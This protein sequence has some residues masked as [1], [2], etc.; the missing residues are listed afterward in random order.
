MRDSISF[1]S[2]WPGQRD[3]DSVSSAVSWS[4]MV[5]DN[6]TETKRG[7]RESAKLKCG[8]KIRPNI[9]AH[10]LIWNSNQQQ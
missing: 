7:E 5:E 3:S 10:V 4:K 2:T 8:D 9:W 1:F 6:S